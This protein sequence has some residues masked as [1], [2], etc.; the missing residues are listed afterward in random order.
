[1]SE[2]MEE[3]MEKTPKAMMREYV[4]SQHFESTAEVMA[5]MKEMFADVLQQVM[6]CE[7]EEKLGYEK[8]ERMSEAGEDGMSKNY[9][10]GYSKKTVKTQLG[11]VDVRIPR[12]RKGE[13]EPQI[14]GKYDRNADGMEEKIVGRTRAG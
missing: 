11:E 2:R 8:S 4:N 1:M 9:R 6:E 7:L 3:S 12:D 5:A 14:I 13:Y 10:N